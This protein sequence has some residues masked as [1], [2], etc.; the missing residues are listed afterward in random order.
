MTLPLDDLRV[1]EFGQLLAGPFCGQL[2]G[3]F[4]AEVIKVEDPATG[5][6]MRQWGREKPH[7]KSL[8]WPVVARNKKSI[9]CNLRDP[10]GQAL[11][12]R[13]IDTA[14]I[15]VENFRP[16]TLER[17]GMAPET[18][19]KTNPGLIITRVTG[20]GQTGPY[21]SR[22]G[23]GSIGEAMGGIRYV[24]GEPGSPPVRAGISLGDSLAAVYACLGTLVAVHS[25][26][27][28]GR[29]QIVDSAIY[30]A[31]LAMMESLLPEWAVAG[32]QRERTGATLPNVSPSN[33]YPT[34]DGDLILIA[35]NQDTVFG[36]LAVAMGEPELAADPRYATHS[37][38][39]A[40][41]AELDDHIARWTSGRAAEDLLGLLHANGVPAGRIFRAKDMFGD[42]HFAAREA[43]VTVPHPDFGELPMQNAT[44]R[45]SETPGAVRTAGPALGEHN[46]EI[47][48]GLIGLDETEQAR[49][50]A[51][52][53]I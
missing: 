19:W 12:R 45:L 52:G 26:G 8:W 24:M 20:Y 53:I 35:A 27:R 17:W 22:A 16:G 43:I 38:R 15:V 32:Y 31:V 21:A 33:V 9:T 49:L 41:M 2:L 37:A 5:D 13:L 36:R 28:T 11:I 1:V 44:P 3:D 18:L 34:G 14:D 29:G 46:T 23:F 42:P 51:A 39:G 48:G 25:R 40:A 30:E 50:R 4:G 7:G 6:P 10:E 47:Y